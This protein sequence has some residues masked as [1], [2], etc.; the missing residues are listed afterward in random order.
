MLHAG[1]LP[2]GA[3][4]VGCSEQPTK[5]VLGEKLYL[6]VEAFKCKSAVKLNSVSFLEQT[7]RKLLKWKVQNGKHRIAMRLEF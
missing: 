3:L 1:R 7:K 4:L 6:V 2:L 5:A